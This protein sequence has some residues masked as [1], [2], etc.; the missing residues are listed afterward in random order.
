MESHGTNR[1]NRTQCLKM[2]KMY[3]NVPF[4]LEKPPGNGAKKPDVI[5]HNKEISTWTLFEGTVCQVDKIAERLKEKQTKHIELCA[6]STSVYQVN[7]VFDFLGGQHEQLGNDLRS[8]KNIPRIAAFTLALWPAHTCKGHAASEFFFQEIKNGFTHNRPEYLSF[9]YRMNASIF[10][11][12][13]Q[14]ARCKTLK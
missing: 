5:V 7:I 8:I 10:I 11:Q 14:P 12:W 13:D 6:T 1:A 9:S 3:R 4:I 2:A